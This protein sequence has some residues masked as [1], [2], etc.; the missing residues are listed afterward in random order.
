M[1]FR[2]QAVSMPFR[3]RADNEGWDDVPGDGEHLAD[4]PEPLAPVTD[5]VRVL[6][7]Q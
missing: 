3:L 6:G 4:V 2:W 5:L 7:E 1:R